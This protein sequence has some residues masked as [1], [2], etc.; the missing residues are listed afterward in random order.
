[1]TG[2]RPDVQLDQHGN[3][4]PIEYPWEHGAAHVPAEFEIELYD[5]TYLDLDNPDPDL[6]TIDQ[7]AYALPHVKR[8][9]G[10]SA[11]PISASPSTRCASPH[12]CAPGT[13]RP[14]GTLMPDQSTLLPIV[15]LWSGLCVTFI[16]APDA[17]LRRTWLARKRG[18]R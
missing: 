16:Y 8:Y 3:P 5:G 13:T 14:S 17:F 10:Q 18:P 11:S 6:I 1:M 12:G 4:R 9:C 2:D 7:I 15:G